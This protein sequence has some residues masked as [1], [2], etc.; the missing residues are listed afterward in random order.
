[1]SDIKSIYEK[2]A[3]MRVELQSKNLLRQERIHTVNMTIMSFRIFFHHVTALQHH[4][5]HCLNLQS[6]KT[7][8]VSLLLIWRI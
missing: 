7:Q 1:M 8:Q 2:L 3:Q 5:K 6:M 4:I